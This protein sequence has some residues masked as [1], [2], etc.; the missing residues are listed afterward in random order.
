M[1]EWMNEIR[2]KVKEMSIAGAYLLAKRKELVQWERM[3][4]Q[5]REGIVFRVISGN[6]GDKRWVRYL[7]HR[8]GKHTLKILTHLRNLKGV[9]WLVH[10]KGL[11]IRFL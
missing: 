11:W 10:I 4:I 8:W 3:K 1:V 6:V 5:K 7:E 2:H 9:D